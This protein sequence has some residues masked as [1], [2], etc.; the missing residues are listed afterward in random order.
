MLVLFAMAL[1]LSMPRPNPVVVLTPYSPVL[2]SL[3]SSITTSLRISIIDTVA[4]S[5]MRDFP[6]RN[7]IAGLI[8]FRVKVFSFSLVFTF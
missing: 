2:W 7:Q 5:I 1:L 8:I 6:F 3:Q 4:V